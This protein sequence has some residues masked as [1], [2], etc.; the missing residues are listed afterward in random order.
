MSKS[1]TRTIVEDAHIPTR[2]THALEILYV[3]LGVVEEYQ[4]LAN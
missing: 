1:K 2:M 4:R 3:C